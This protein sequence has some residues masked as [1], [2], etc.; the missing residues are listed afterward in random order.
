[1]PSRQKAVRLKQPN[2]AVTS[3]SLPT[4]LTTST[5][6]LSNECCLVKLATPGY[7]GFSSRRGHGSSLFYCISR[8]TL[9]PLQ[10]RIH[11]V[12]CCEADQAPASHAEVGNK[13]SCTLLPHT[14]SH[15]AQLYHYWLANCFIAL[16]CQ[17]SVPWQLKSVPPLALVPVVCYSKS[18]E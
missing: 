7:Q 3:R 16:L 9:N 14:S 4:V 2:C 11:R 13:W 17:M 10:A 15:H 8:P 18:R 1:M 5:N 12:P 6:T